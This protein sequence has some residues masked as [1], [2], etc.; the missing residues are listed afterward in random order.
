MTKWLFCLLALLLFQCSP[1][2]VNF[3]NP[4]IDFSQFKTFR[5]I[6]YKTDNS[7]LSHNNRPIYQLLESQISSEMNRREYALSNINPDLLVRYELISN[8]NTQTQSSN[9]GYYTIPMMTISHFITSVLLVELIDI[10]TKTIVWQASVDLNQLNR[11]SDH[12]KIIESAVRHIFNTYLRMAGTNN[13]Y[14]NLVLK[15]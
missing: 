13:E 15:K 11:N 12:Q 5:V 9:Y 3:T 14:Q 2:V 7:Q 4:K 10:E 8:Q 1:K 6:N